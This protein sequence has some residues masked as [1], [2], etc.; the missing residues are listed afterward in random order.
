[1]ARG[2]KCNNEEIPRSSARRR[3]NQCKSGWRPETRMQNSTDEIKVAAARDNESFNKPRRPEMTQ[4]T[5]AAQPR[6]KLHQPMM[7]NLA[8][9]R[10]KRRGDWGRRGTKPHPRTGPEGV[11]KIR[12]TNQSAVLTGLGD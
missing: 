9:H 2:S 3:D 10:E 6:S 12:I 7:T 1:M 4:T 11:G 8:D 5:T